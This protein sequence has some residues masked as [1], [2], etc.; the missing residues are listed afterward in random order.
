[1]ISRQDAI[2]L[3]DTQDLISIGMQADTVRSRWHPEGIVTYCID[4][5]DSSLEIV[6][7]VSFGRDETIEQYIDHL[8]SIRKLQDRGEPFTVVI[9]SLDGTAAEYLK[10]L[11]IS[12]IY[13]ENIPH[14]QTSSTLGL[15]ICQIA[16]RFGA[17]DIESGG[18]IQQRPTE[19]ELRCL[20][21]DAGFIPKQRDAMFRT[22]YLR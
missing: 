4:E 9:P 13:L 22:Y 17:D 8:D 2:K 11:A 5:T 3:F 16:L 19:E 1:V 20:I 10:M 6:A 21:R 7:R 15:K 12:R 18:E 14:V